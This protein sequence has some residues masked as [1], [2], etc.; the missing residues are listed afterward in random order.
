MLNDCVDFR[1]DDVSFG[2]KI[3]WVNGTEN[4]SKSHSNQ[5]RFTRGSAMTDRDT[6]I[7]LVAGG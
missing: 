5:I 1:E 4:S 3:G 2:E 6:W 7:H